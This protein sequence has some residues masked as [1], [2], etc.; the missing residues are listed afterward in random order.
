MKRMILLAS[1]L[2]LANQLSQSQTITVPREKVLTKTGETVPFSAELFPLNSG[3]G[4]VR[5]KNITNIPNASGMRIHFSIVSAPADP[6]WA[7]QVKDK[8]GRSAS[9]IPASAVVGKDFWSDEVPG[10]EATVEIITIAEDNPEH[11]LQLKITEIIK[12]TPPVTPQSITPPDQLESIA[13]QSSTVKSLGKAVA[14]LRF[15]ADDDGGSY[16]CTAF[17]ISKDLMMTNNHCIKT[18]DEMKSGLADFDY[19]DVGSAETGLR[20]KELIITNPALDF[21]ILRLAKAMPAD[22][23]SLQLLSSKPTQGQALMIIEHP[24]G[25]PK[26]VSRQDC[27]VDNPEMGGISPQLTDFAHR[28]DTLGGASGSPTFDASGTDVKV[29]GLHHLGFDTVNQVLVNRAVRIGLIID[30][31]RAQKPGLLA[32]LGIP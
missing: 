1:I 28:C 25:Q 4:R 7:V 6:T 20:F 3:I 9:I 29:I 26:K 19:D 13:G 30:F 27:V 8:T 12:S 17:L 11:P 21:T 15:K 23:G 18:D 24:G 10:N 16:V 31:I 2:V 22:R 5:F 32:E 14:R